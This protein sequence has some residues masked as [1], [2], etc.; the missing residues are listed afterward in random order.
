MAP[1]NGAQSAA[2][3]LAALGEMFMSQIDGPPPSAKRAK[4]KPFGASANASASSPKL[5]PKLGPAAAPEGETL[6]RSARKKKN[7]KE[8]QKAQAAGGLPASASQP[9]SATAAPAAAKKDNKSGNAA[10]QS[11]AAAAPAAAAATKT[12]PAASVLADAK[13]PASGPGR[14][15]PPRMSAAEKKRFMSGKIS[16]LRST[17]QVE[18]DRRRRQKSEKTE[19]E[20]EFNSTLREILEF[21]TPQLGKQQQRQYHEQK[22]RA[23][24]GT[25]EKR[26]KM[27]YKILQ[28]H[29]KNAEE[30]R[31]KKIAKDK[32]L[33]V[34]K[35]ASA[36]R[37]QWAVD[38]HIK[39][40]KEAL[41]EKTARRND[42][43]LR[44]GLGAK[45]HKGMAVISKKE[46]AKLSRK[47]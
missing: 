33:G 47:M 36:H 22:I 6:S 25:I 44:V 3:R 43:L 5:S 41:K 4:H 45:E 1:V 13:L 28:Q 10:R 20:K 7:K 34:T 37:K 29:R 15:G 21:V 19:E 40:K 9:P 39:Q 14:P 17:P 42:G 11:T 35:D 18:E 12:Q 46:V 32:L 23:L 8:R 24:G 26:D 16:D 31:K 27:P 30:T 2:D 38:R